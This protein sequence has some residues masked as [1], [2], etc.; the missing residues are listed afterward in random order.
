MWTAGVCSLGV[1]TTLSESESDA[2][3]FLSDPPNRE[4]DAIKKNKIQSDAIKEIKIQSDAIKKNKIQS[5]P[6]NVFKDQ[7]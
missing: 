5:D 6:T 2:I 4:S 7:F 1:C 3:F